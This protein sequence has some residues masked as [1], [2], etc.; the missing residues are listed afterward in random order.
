MSK[1]SMSEKAPCFRFGPFELDAAT[2]ELCRNG[3]RLP[4]QG[5]PLQILELLLRAPGQM[6]SREQLRQALWPEGTYVDFNDSLNAGI[7]RLR[8]AL[9]DDADQPRFIETLP[10]RGYRFLGTVDVIANGSCAN[11]SALP[12]AV[13][14]SATETAVPPPRSVWR[15]YVK[16]VPPALLLVTL[17]VVLAGFR[18][19]RPRPALTDK[20]VIVL[21]DLDNRT[22][23]PVF[24][25]TLR[26]ALA[27]DLEQSPFLSVLPDLRMGEILKQM[28]RAPG[29]LI[30]PEIGREICLRTSSKALLEGSIVSIGNVYALQ[31]KATDCRTGYTL[32]AVDG[33]EAKREK[34]LLALG[35]SATTLRTRLGESLPSVEKYDKPLQDVTTSSLEALQAYSEG[36][37]VVRQKG[38]AAAIPFFRRALELDP[39]FASAYCYLGHLYGDM[40][41]YELAE[42]NVRSCFELSD[43]LS[44][45]ET[46]LNRGLYYHVVTGELEKA[47][48]QF[49]LLAQEY[50]REFS[51]HAAWGGNLWEMGAYHQAVVELRE[52]ARLQPDN[53]RASTSLIASLRAVGR[54]DEAQAVANEAI[55]RNPDS[56]SLHNQLYT[57]AFLRNDAAARQHEL[58]WA[59]G[60]PVES[61]A[62]SYEALTQAYYGRLGRARAL[63]RAA[64]AAGLKNHAT[65]PIG[66]IEA[67][68]AGVEAWLGN[69]AQARQTTRAALAL[70]RQQGTRIFVSLALAA[71][72][73]SSAARR[74]LDIVNKNYPVDTVVQTFWNPIVRGQLELKQGHAQRAL[75]LLEP[76]R[77]HDLT[78]PTMCS[79]YLRGQAYLAAG[80]GA[81]AAAEFQNILDHRG[82]VTNKPTAVLAHLYLGRARAVEARSLQGPAA[83]ESRAKARA[84]YQDFLTL[85][86]DADPDIPILRQARVELAKLQ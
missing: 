10:R 62:L 60:K 72:G 34:V 80:N 70:S 1:Y 76:V 77:T 61:T 5:Q 11:I 17:S 78:D 15:Q 67:F 3:I 30:T 41:E 25:N 74:Q 56:P 46:Y 35:E 29:D 84:A 6:V 53:S 12:K 54:L 69:S 14:S 71:A 20:D 75:D 55:S 66:Q 18:Y 64:V 9:E 32:A 65:E 59:M 58:Q 63:T 36:D 22:G 16:I 13:E 33:E 52:A 37:L 31:L 86:K 68:Q 42:Q 21:A 57:L 26:T 82:L 47:G 39:A 50:P 73:D 7:R 24:N 48:E 4:I 28:N 83:E 85:W 79:V 27:I 40:R 81:A 49:R 45:K 38:A 19:L 44:A 8:L 2:G 43:R 51:G 23:E